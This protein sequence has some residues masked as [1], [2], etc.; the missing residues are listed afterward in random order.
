V[1]KRGSLFCVVAPSGAGKTTLVRALVNKVPG[2]QVS[3]STTTRA[4]RPADME[5]IDYY[6]VTHDQFKQ[7]IEAGSFLEYAEV[8]GNFYGTSRHWVESHL[9]EGVDVILEIDWQG[10]RYIKGTF[11][12]ALGIFVL[13]PSLMALNARLVG[14]AQDS[15]DVISVRMK[16]AA[17]DIMH[18]KEQ[19]FVIINADLELALKEL[20]HIVYAA[21]LRTQIAQGRLDNLLAELT[22][23]G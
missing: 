10:A 16:Q 9:A 1:S 13:P 8:F 6:F 7:Q 4:M 20:E 12:H 2:I 5:G 18:Y 17:D 19:D 22:Q 11:P 14:R 21:R 23:S 3:I 15:E